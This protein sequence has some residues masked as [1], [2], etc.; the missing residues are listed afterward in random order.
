MRSIG[1]YVGASVIA[2]LLSGSFVPLAS[3]HTLPG[4]YKFTP[5]PQVDE[6]FAK[7]DSTTSP[8]CSAAAAKDGKLIYSRGYG[9]ANLDH[10]IPN[11]PQTPFH[12][13]SVSKQFTAASIVL[14]AQEGKL[15]LDDDVR[16][17]LPEVPDLGATITL[18]Q[19]IHHTSGVR[20]QW[21]LLGLAGWRYS[22]DRINDDDVLR[23]MTRQR[24][25]NFAPNSRYLYSNMG[26]TLLA[27]VVKR[28]S[29]Q[30]LREFTT[31]RIFKPLG[32]GNSH[33]RND[34]AEIV[35]GFANGY[36]RADDSFKTSVTNFDT[37][38]AT[39]LLATAEDLLRWD[40]NFYTGQVGGAAFTEQMLERGVLNDGE[41]ITY[42]FGLMHD[43]YRGLE[44]VGH[45]GAD[46][47][48]RATVLRFPKQHFG[49]TVV[50]NI[51]EA[52]PDVLAKGIADVYLS[53]EL[54]PK[55]EQDPTTSRSIKVSAKA[56]HDKVGMYLN[57]L[58]GQFL[59][60]VEKDGRLQTV[61]PS[62]S[63]Q[64]LIPVGAN[65]FRFEPF[66][67]LVF[68]FSGAGE[69]RAV[70]MRMG[71]QKPTTF[72]FVPEFSPS[73]TELNEYAGLFASEELDVRYRML[74]KDGSLHVATLKSNP[75]PMQ[76]VTKDMFANP[77]FT[78]T[79][80]R[81][82]SGR[83][84]GCSVSSGRAWNNDFVKLAE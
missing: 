44:T 13:A 79:F 16:K 8:G 28:V 80:V 3:A 11:T 56:L 20:D 35:P 15:S 51:A 48:Y 25:L 81:D 21:E 62:G 34:H 33:F 18:R 23:L 67:A 4:T 17:Y 60:I 66:P 58:D 76:A 64:G 47:G 2:T 41:K 55:T 82:A 54:Q 83:I 72:V 24:K 77:F 71:E 36:E 57:R 39:S 68:E 40:E 46:A 59:R 37:T 61:R 63:T 6:V 42:A 69:Q 19:L 12:V 65:R 30:S 43:T 9:M 75:M 78:T 73:T 29:G 10:S 7:F 1:R 74:I 38:G 70:T 31:E 27:L 49:I 5:N 53:A 14:L 26:Y 52:Q 84:T 50:C 22:L 32:M 45:G